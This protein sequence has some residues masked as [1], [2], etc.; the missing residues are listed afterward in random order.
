MITNTA[1]I[2]Y[3]EFKKK[4]VN[5]VVLIKNVGII[6]Y[7]HIYIDMGDLITLKKDIFQPVE[8]I[9]FAPYGNKINFDLVNE[10]DYLDFFSIYTIDI[11]CTAG[12]IINNG[13]YILKS[14][15][16]KTIGTLQT[17]DYPTGKKVKGASGVEYTYKSEFNKSITF[18]PSLQLISDL[19]SYIGPISTINLDVVDT[20]PTDSNGDINIYKIN[21]NVIYDR[22]PR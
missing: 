21:G 6:Y 11:G 13:S 19:T 16:E 17:Y 9:T 10:N 22:F 4:L 7:N 14:D 1:S 20:V 3:D 8:F 18:K 5:D 15:D 2:S 12:E